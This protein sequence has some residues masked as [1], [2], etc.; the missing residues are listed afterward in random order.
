MRR[1]AAREGVW[2]M[3]P[4]FLGWQYRTKPYGFEW[5]QWSFRLGRRDRVRAW[6]QETLGAR[7][8]EVPIEEGQP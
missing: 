6:V 5:G 7:F 8:T 1:F 3:R 4:A 2:Q